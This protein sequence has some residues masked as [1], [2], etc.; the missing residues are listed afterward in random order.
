MEY[1]SHENFKK[2]LNEMH[3]MDHDGA[4]EFHKLPADHEEGFERPDARETGEENEL[5]R[6]TDVVEA[7]FEGDSQITRPD[8]DA[9]AEAIRNA[10]SKSRGYGQGDE[11]DFTVEYLM[12][13]AR[14]NQRED[15]K[16]KIIAASHLEETL[17]AVGK[18]DDDVNN[19]GKVDKT[20]KYLLKRRAAVGKAINKEEW[21]SPYDGGADDLAAMA[22]DAAKDDISKDVKGAAYHIG[23]KVGYKGHSFTIVIGPGGKAVLKHSTGKLLSP[24]E[25]IKILKQAAIEKKF[26]DLDEYQFD[27]MYPDDPGPFEGKDIEKTIKEFLLREDDIDWDAVDDMQADEDQTDGGIEEDF[28]PDSSDFEQAVV[29]ELQ[30]MGEDELTSEEYEKALEA[31][32]NPKIVEKLWGVHPKKAAAALAKMVRGKEVGEGINSAPMQATGPT[33]QTVEEES[34]VAHLTSEEKEQVKQYIESIKTIKEQIAKLVG[35]G[36]MKEGGDTTGLVMTPSTVSEDDEMA[37]GGSEH[38]EIESHLSPKFHEAFH[39]ITGMIIDE[40]TK[41]GF[42]EDQIKSFLDHEIEEKAK[43]W[44]SGQY[45]ENKLR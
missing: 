27:Q 19:D 30:Y 40:L 11:V 21:E 18:E 28:N 41:A 4:D 7:T 9:L 10:W 17:D 45:G 20:D 2:L 39:K 3:T 44:I 14:K 16:D 38:E 15:L 24:E 37:K 5:G 22:K 43:E 42:P 36:K 12:D 33:I 1:I 25:S 13:W 23:D 34:S 26:H 31:L 29:K 6:I 35:K 32:E 8:I